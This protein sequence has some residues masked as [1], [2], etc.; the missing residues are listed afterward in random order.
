MVYNIQLLRGQTE[1]QAPK[2]S[3]GW[4]P[5]ERVVGGGSSSAR[6]GRRHNLHR[7]MLLSWVQSISLL[8]AL[9]RTCRVMRQLA[10]HDACIFRTKLPCARSTG[11]FPS[12]I[13]WCT[14]MYMCIMHCRT[15]LYSRGIALSDK[16]F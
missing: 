13:M 4:S 8:Q 1:A 16:Y 9:P 15:P 2:Y 3:V 10:L 6:T 7:P 14:G 11:I 12:V 5:F